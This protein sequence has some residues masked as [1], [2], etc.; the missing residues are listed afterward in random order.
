MTRFRH[1]IAAALLV[2]GG[3]AHA[4]IAVVTNAN[5]GIAQMSRSDVINIFMGRYRKLPNGELALPIDLAPVKARFYQA[6]VDKN[7]AEINS[8]W[9]RL[10]FSGQASPPHQAETTAQAIS[11]VVHNP[12]AL[13]YVDTHHLTSEL[14]VVL[15]LHE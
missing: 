13:G 15:V 4:D 12:S 7:L 8:W 6:L 10:V 5:S 11:L 9:A 2:T 14:H 3:L 1:F